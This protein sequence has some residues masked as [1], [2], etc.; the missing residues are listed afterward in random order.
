MLINHFAIITMKFHGI[1]MYH[2]IYFFVIKEDV[3]PEDFHGFF[4]LF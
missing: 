2:I 3:F 4:M 1:Y